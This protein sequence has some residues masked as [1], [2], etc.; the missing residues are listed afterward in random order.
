MAVTDRPITPGDITRFYPLAAR[1]TEVHVGAVLDIAFDHILYGLLQSSAF[2]ALDMTFKGGTAL[3]KYYLGHKSRFSFDLDFDV[4][5]GAEDLVAEQV[6]R[7]SFDQFDFTVYERR[8][9]YMIEIASDLLAT[10]SVPVKMDFSTR[11]LWLPTE[12]TPP[13]GNPMHGLYAFDP[14]VVPV[15]NLVENLSEKLSRWQRISVVRDLYDLAALAGYVSPGLVAELWVLKSYRNMIEQRHRLQQGD[16]AASVENITA[17]RQVSD[18]D[19]NDLVLPGTASASDKAQLVREDIRIVASFCRT[20]A[21]CMTP[22][23]S[24]IASDRGA[25]EWKVAQ[26]IQKLAG[27]SASGVH[28]SR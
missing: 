11:G 23:L 18:F 14:P 27:Q 1:D 3:R 17:Q 12:W 16:T 13:I 6:N 8:G 20:I 5:S 10:D 2:D 28:R 9:H 22:E 21:E 26:R 7:M 4:A 25:L 15:I 19:L 24:E